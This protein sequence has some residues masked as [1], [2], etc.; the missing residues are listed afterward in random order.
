MNVAVNSATGKT[1]VAP[2]PSTSKTEAAAANA[3][4]DGHT[5]SDRRIVVIVI[6]VFLILVII[7]AFVIFE[8]YKNRTGIFTP[9]T[10]GGIPSN[11]FYPL[12][13]ITPLTPAEQQARAAQ[14]SAFF[15]AGN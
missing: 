2:P 10:P 1:V 13:T 3:L 12:G 9:F 7:Y 15:A 11:G 4:S 14:V 8:W 5:N 6:V